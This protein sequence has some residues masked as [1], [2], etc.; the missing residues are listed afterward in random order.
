MKKI[1]VV[2]T[3]QIESRQFCLTKKNQFKIYTQKMSYVKNSRMLN[4]NKLGEKTYFCLDTINMNELLSILFVYAKLYGNF[5]I[6]LA[7]LF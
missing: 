2:Q 5:K 1:G 4:C 7:F 3:I 6:V